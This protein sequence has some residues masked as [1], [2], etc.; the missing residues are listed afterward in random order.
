MR[1]CNQLGS[2]VFI[3]CNS[4]NSGILNGDLDNIRLQFVTA[5]RHL[6]MESVVMLAN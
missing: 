6:G 3:C 2:A 5:S 1:C 4:C